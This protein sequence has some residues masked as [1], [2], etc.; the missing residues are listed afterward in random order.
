M[1][2]RR[3]DAYR[4]RSHGPMS[5]RPTFLAKYT[6]VLAIGCASR[7]C[8]I[9]KQ[10]LLAGQCRGVHTHVILCANPHTYGTRRPICL[11]RRSM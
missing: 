11:R 2:T 1:L 8:A 6:F 7:V 9:H 3:M 4:C 10:G 5:T